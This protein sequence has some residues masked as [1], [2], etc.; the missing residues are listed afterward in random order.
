[1][2]WY[3][4]QFLFYLLISIVQILYSFGIFFLMI[5]DDLLR[6]QNMNKAQPKEAKPLQSSKILIAFNNTFYRLLDMKEYCHTYSDQVIDDLLLLSHNLSLKPFIY[7]FD[8]L[9][10]FQFHSRLKNIKSHLG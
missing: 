8:W 2:A 4:W 7:N 10:S 9:S 1:M 5:I 3:W 6:D